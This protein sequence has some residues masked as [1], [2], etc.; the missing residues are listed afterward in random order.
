VTL[1]HAGYRTPADKPACP[2]AQEFV[3]SKRKRYAGWRP[4]YLIATLKY[5]SQACNVV[6]VLAFHKDRE[7]DNNIQCLTLAGAGMCPTK[8]DPKR[9]QV[10]IRWTLCLS[11]IQ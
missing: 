10:K 6:L 5:S 3:T 2:E 8:Y 1:Q 9:Q 4:M 11:S 7:M